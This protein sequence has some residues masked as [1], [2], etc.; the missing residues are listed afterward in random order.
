MS[1]ERDERHHV[2][3]PEPRVHAVVAIE[4]DALD[5]GRCQRAQRS[6]G[7]ARLGAGQRE[8]GA[9]VIGVVVQVEERRAARGGERVEH[10]DVAP[11]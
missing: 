10:G 8:H 7:V 6:L 1:V 11:F 5:D 2:E 9:V 4:V 3:C